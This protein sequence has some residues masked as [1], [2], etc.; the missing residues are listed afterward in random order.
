MA[1][2]SRFGD[3]LYWLMVLGGGV[4]LAP[5]LIL[6][7]WLE[8]RASLELCALRAEQVAQRRAEVVKLRQQREQLERDDAYLLRLAREDLNLE[9][10]DVRRI[11][12]EP[13][14]AAQASASVQAVDAAHIPADE[15]APELSALVEKALQRYPLAYMFVHPRTRPPLMLIGGG[16]VVAAVV[17]L[18]RA[19]CPRPAPPPPSAT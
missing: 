1:Q 14:P 13:G 3:L 4:L 17:L 9:I 19:A 15:L 8:Y 12:V 10:P 11:V 6:P 7:A 5:C 18:G 2:P 16:L